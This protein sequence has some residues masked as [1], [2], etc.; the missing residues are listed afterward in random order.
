MRLLEHILLLKLLLSEALTYE[1]EEHIKQVQKNAQVLAASLLKK[2]ITVNRNKVPF[3]DKSPFVTSG[4]RVGA[5]AVITQGLKEKQMEKIVDLI[6]RVIMKNEDEKTI[7]DV[8]KK[9]NKMMEEY[10]LY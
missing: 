5:A 7:K 3:D 8:R 10:P 9:V 1:Y 6:D 2:D 4:I